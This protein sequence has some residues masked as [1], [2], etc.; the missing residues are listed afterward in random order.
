MCIIGALIASPHASNAA[1]QRPNLLFVIVDDLSARVGGAFRQPG[2][3][4]A[5]PAIDRLQ[6]EGIS[7]TRA[8]TR[9]TLCSPSRTALLTGLRPDTTRLWTIGPYFRD[10]T[11]AG[12]TRVT[13]PQA[14]KAVGYN[15]TGAGKVWHPGTSSG[16]LRQWG[17]GDVGGDDMPYSWS[18]TTPPGADSRTQYWECDA[19]VNSTGQ[20]SASAGLPHGAGCVTSAACIA[21]LKVY[22]GTSGA[23][24][25]ATPCA[26]ECYVDN[27][28]AKYTAGVLTAA[29]AAP[30]ASPFAFFLGFKRPHLGL[31]VPIRYLDGY[32]T[33][34]PLAAHRMPPSGMPKA[35]WST[36]GEIRSFHDVPPWVE[37]N[38]TFPGML[39]DAKHAE[40]RR[41]YYASVT[42]MDAQLGAV[43]DTLDATRLRES[44]WVVF[45]GDHGW[46]L[47]EHG[48]W[49]KVTLAESV[50]RVPLIVA[51][52]TGPAGDAYR[53]NAT[54]GA[55]VHV[56]LMD[57]FPTFMD[58]LN[59][60]QAVPAGQL[61]GQS[62]V[63]LLL[64][65]APPTV[66]STGEHDDPMAHEASDKAHRAPFSF[67]LTQIVR[68]DRANCTPPDAD[69]VPPFNP[70]SSD[71]IAAGVPTADGG[72]AA[73]CVMGMSIRVIGWRYTLW[74]GFD[75]GSR[76]S[77]STA[78]GGGSAGPVWSDVRGEELYDHRSDDSPI[79]PG[80]TDGDADFN[81]SE[82]ANLAYDP[83][84]AD[85]RAALNAQLQAAW[86]PAVP[87]AGT[88]LEQAAIYG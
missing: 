20:S 79:A 30:D 16:G 81:T 86:G 41:A 24:W 46:S 68:Q 58:L 66:R 37:V 59:A 25:V 19:W 52:P 31:Q 61:E 2:L 43:L 40:L 21:C 50:A 18:Y 57:L 9:V 60:S 10:T 3:T 80:E 12:P 29:A 23:S 22:N 74:C 53:R 85:M 82:L 88:A 35:G 13:F 51:P 8:Y 84:F 38:S 26:D 36:N 87:G 34:V 49:A 63:P 71:P 54:V 15:T 48:N 77:S 32:A 65:D 6:R 14:L 47:G 69:L 27:M 56:T 42:W 62:L 11:L 5:T 33:D 78:G 83:A 64:G 70:S 67:A 76:N 72:S 7:F 44:T 4:P 75:Y 45:C 28:I 73:D 1:P 17:G 55:G 39:R